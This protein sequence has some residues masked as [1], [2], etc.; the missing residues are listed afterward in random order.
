VSGR[1]SKRPQT[2]TTLVN[3]LFT[4]NAAVLPV[5]LDRTCSN[6]KLSI[7]R[8]RQ[9]QSAQRAHS[10]RNL[11]RG[12]ESAKQILKPSQ[13]NVFRFQS[14]KKPSRNVLSER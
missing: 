2:A 5:Q 9:I 14:Q 6:E 13:H 4:N 10:G 3:P 7:Q 8:F 12:K 11:E 1:P